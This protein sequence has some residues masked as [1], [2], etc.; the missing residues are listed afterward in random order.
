MDQVNSCNH[1]TGIV[2]SLIRAE[3]R[4]YASVKYAI[5]GSDDELPPAPHQAIFWTNS[6]ILWKSNV[7]YFGVN[8]FQNAAW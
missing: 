5:I 4:I 1:V 7:K 8:L 6:V 2:N 3:W